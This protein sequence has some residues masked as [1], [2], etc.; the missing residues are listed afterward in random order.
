MVTT[1][2]I[3]STYQLTQPINAINFEAWN[4]VT[5]DL[6]QPFTFDVDLF[7]GNNDGADGIV[8]CYNRLVQM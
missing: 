2:P 3:P 8:F 5:L 7:F 1:Q 6:T 4:S